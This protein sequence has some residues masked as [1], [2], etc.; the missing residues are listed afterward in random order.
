[1]ARAMATVFNV[2]IARHFVE[3]RTL[4]K[5]LGTRRKVYSGEEG[6]GCVHQENPLTINIDI[7]YRR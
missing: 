5:Q 4:V 7:K 3:T 1:M 6:G 2:E